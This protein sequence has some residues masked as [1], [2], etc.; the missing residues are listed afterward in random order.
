MSFW[1]GPK[2]HLFIAWLLSVCSFL[3]LLNPARR[4]RCDCGSFV[5]NPGGFLLSSVTK[6]NVISS[7][8]ASLE[9]RECIYAKLSAPVTKQSLLTLT[10][11][12]P[13]CARLDQRAHTLGMWPSLMSKLSFRDWVTVA[14]T[15]KRLVRGAEGE[16]REGG[17][18][19][20]A[21]LMSEV[22][23]FTRHSRR[24]L[25]F[26]PVSLCIILE[27]NLECIMCSCSVVTNH[28]VLLQFNVNVSIL[29]RFSH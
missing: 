4:G 20:L 15:P 25:G 29:H 28:V 16:G 19:E 5:S 26:I 2:L 8:I 6:T 3:C 17:A 22:E 23:F 9:G 7:K 11:S 1:L 12:T 24:M 10:E 14:K 13:G 18:L 21:F 27:D